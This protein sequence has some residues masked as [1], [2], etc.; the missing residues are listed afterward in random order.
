MGSPP[1]ADPVHTD[2]FLRSLRLNAMAATSAAAVTSRPSDAATAMPARMPL[3]SVT[4][5]RVGTA[6]AE[7]CAAPVLTRPTRERNRIALSRLL[8][9]LGWTPPVSVPLGVATDA[10]RRVL[11]IDGVAPT[12]VASR[13]GCDGCDHD[14]PSATARLLAA[15]TP[16]TASTGTRAVVRDSATV[17]AKGRLSLP[18]WQLATI[19]VDATDALAVL[20]L[21]E[22]GLLAVTSASSLALHGI[23]DIR[24]PADPSTSPH[25]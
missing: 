13:C 1:K 24:I 10:S 19:K 14:R 17:D 20:G 8:A 16:L 15:A 18:D 25:R 12:A 4:E 7:H 11:W 9:E 5:L 21:R 6:L 22:L 3:A 23:G 2:P